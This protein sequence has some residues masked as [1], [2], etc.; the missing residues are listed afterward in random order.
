MKPRGLPAGIFAAALLLAE[1]RLCSQTIAFSPV[2]PTVDQSVEITFPALS[3]CAVI[4]IVQ[5]RPPAAGNG[6][7][8]LAFASSPCGL[9]PFLRH[10]TTQIGPLPLGTYRVTAYYARGASVSVPLVVSRTGA[11]SGLAVQ[12]ARPLAGEPVEAVIDAFCPLAFKPPR[13][14]AEGGRTVVEIEHDPE[15]PVPPVPCTAD[16]SFR[17][18]VSLPPLQ[19]GPHQLRV[20]SREGSA[21]AAEAELVFGV[22]SPHGLSLLGDRFTVSAQWSAPGFP[23]AAARGVQL[24]EDSGYFYF[25]GP[26]NVELVVK[27][28]DGC[29]VNR[30]YWAFLAGLTNVKLTVYVYD[31]SHGQTQIYTSPAGVP[32]APVQDTARFATCPGLLEGPRS[33]LLGEAQ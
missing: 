14:V 1:E 12:P 30:R 16:P 20:L 23:A 19:V 33:S 21:P 29:A 13:L 3:A 2:N 24:T 4:P 17:H 28:L 27:L 9:E 8:E 31:T 22:S 25:L 7:I 6:R 15:A 18:T 26:S 11:V 5:F 10:L 32:F